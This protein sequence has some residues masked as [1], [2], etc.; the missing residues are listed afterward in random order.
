VLER[1]DLLRRAIFEELEVLCGEVQYW[2][3]VL[4]RERVNPD[5]IGLDAKR[6]WLLLASAAITIAAA[7]RYVRCLIVSP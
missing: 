3:A 5:E 1:R 6:W 2:L 7:A 4:R